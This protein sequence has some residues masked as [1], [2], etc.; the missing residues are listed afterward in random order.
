MPTHYG[1]ALSSEE[2]RPSDLVR[3]AQQAERCGFEFVS[4]SDHYHPWID[5]QG[6]APFVWAVVG[7]VAS[8]TTRLALGTGVTCPS[9]RIH[10]AVLAQ[11]AA[12]AADMMPGRFFFGVGSGENLNEHILGDRWPEAGVRIEMM[13]EAVEVIRKLWRGGYQSHHGSYFTVEN[14]RLY[15]LPERLP[16]VIVSAFGPKAAEV[17]ARIGDGLWTTSPQAEVLDAWRDAGGS[18]PVY[19]QLTVCY[20]EDEGQARKVAHEWWPNTSI[21]GNLSQELPLP[22]HLEQAAEL[23]TEDMVAESVVCGP[24]PQRYVDKLREFERLGF[25][26]LYLHQVGPDQE[27]FFRFWTEQLAPLL[28]E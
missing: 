26:H 21:P 25:T 1:Y 18:G 22:E 23:V 17:A 5:R 15:T 27:A 13:E 8:T 20:H 3:Y 12:T 2:H 9:V 28:A 14:A 4:L 24:D 7:G 11:A 10:P 16:P 6:Q 19:G